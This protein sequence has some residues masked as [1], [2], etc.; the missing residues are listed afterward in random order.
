MRII[1]DYLWLLAGL[2]CVWVGLIGLYVIYSTGMP[3]SPATLIFFA[4]FCFY[5]FVKAEWRRNR[6]NYKLPITNYKS[7]NALTSGSSMARTSFIPS[8]L[9]MLC[10][11]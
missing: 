10:I 9:E 8:F 3:S 4:P 1:R 11:S 6:E 7:M 2:G 5:K